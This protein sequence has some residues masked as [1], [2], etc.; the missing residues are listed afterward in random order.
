MS[1]KLNIEIEQGATFTYTV[2]LYNTDNTAFSSSGWTGR[3]QL[4]KHLKSNTKYDFTISMSNGYVSMAMNAASTNN[5]PH[6]LYLYDIEIE[7]S[8]GTIKRI[9]SGMAT[10]SGQITK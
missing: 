7:H 10:V 2:E 6:G 1:K 3:G 5:I 9:L 8:D 4:R